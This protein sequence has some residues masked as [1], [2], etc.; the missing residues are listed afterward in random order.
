MTKRTNKECTMTHRLFGAV[1]VVALASFAAATPSIAKS[2]SRNAS[3]SIAAR[4]AQQSKP[5]P[6]RLRIRN[7]TEP[8]AQTQAFVRYEAARPIFC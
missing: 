7:R 4:T 8:Q 5:A 2:D 6:K 1:A 3:T